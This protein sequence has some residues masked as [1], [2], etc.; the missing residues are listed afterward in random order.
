[1]V[2]KL[3]L[4]FLVPA[5][6]R[7]LLQRVE[8]RLDNPVIGSIDTL[9]DLQGVGADN[10]HLDAADVRWEVLDEGRNTFSLLAGERGLFDGF[11]LVILD[12]KLS[13]I[14]AL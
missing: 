10:L 3:T 12:D 9:S 5:H 11:N 6:L 8:H 2:V 4:V 14:S 7:H 13:H 1:M